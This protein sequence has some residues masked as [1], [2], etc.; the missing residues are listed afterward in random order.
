MK[1]V[2]KFIERHGKFFKRLAIFAVCYIAISFSNNPA[3]NT[4]LTQFFGEY[5]TTAIH[6]TVPTVLLVSEV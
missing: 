4:L 5:I 1:E 2:I 6:A 3:I